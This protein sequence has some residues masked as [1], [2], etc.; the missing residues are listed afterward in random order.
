MN[1]DWIFSGDTYAC[2]LRT[3]GILIQNGCI[4][5][6]RDAGDDEYALPYKSYHQVHE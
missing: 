6:Q 1:K 3:A 4:L 2:G 5:L